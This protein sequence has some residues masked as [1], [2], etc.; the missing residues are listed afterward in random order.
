MDQKN[1]KYLGLLVVIL[2]G[3][4]TTA[5]LYAADSKDSPRKA[6]LEFTKAYFSFNACMA[7]RVCD[8]SLVVDDVDVVKEYI[9]RARENAQESGFSLF[10]QSN[11]LYNVEIHEDINTKNGKGTVSMEFERKAPLRSFFSDE[12]LIEEKAEFEVIQVDGKWKVCGD[13]FDLPAMALASY[14]DEE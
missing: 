11:K 5:L 12:S 2:I 1:T 4:G 13:L 10:Y 9:E 8:E 7:D 3:L 14:D 6:V